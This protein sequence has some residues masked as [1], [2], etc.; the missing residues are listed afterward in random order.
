MTSERET[1]GP[2][3]SRNA[4][5]TALATLFGNGFLLVGTV[6]LGTVSCLLGWIPPRGPL[7]YRIARL[8]SRGVLL[9]SGARLATE[10]AEP[11]DL[12]RPYIFMSNHQSLLDI[13]A[14]LW[15]L[16]GQT[17]FLAKHSLFRIPI[18]G[19]ALKLGGFISIDREDRSRA[20]DSFVAAVE[21]LKSG[22]STLVFPEGT[23]SQD[24][25]LLPFQRG[26]F[27]L[28]L[29]SGLPIVPVGIRGSFEMRPRAAFASRPGCI[30]VRYGRPV[31]VAG[32]GIRD[33]ARLEGEVRRMI[34]ELSRAELAEEA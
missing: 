32:Y 2:R 3:P 30:V 28:A 20:R 33:R 16:P 34:A 19:W 24:G 15:T 8:W 10:F 6:V 4:L 23:R 31:D 11:L 7:V 21:R 9:C 22:A 25:R 18:F 14:L 13:P 26:G 17:R 5:G 29:K 12:R 1:A 27:L